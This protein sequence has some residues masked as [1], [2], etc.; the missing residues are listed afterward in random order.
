MLKRNGIAFVADEVVTGFGRTGAMF[1]SDTFG[2][3][4]DH[5]VIAKGITSGYFPL[6]AVAIGSELYADLETGSDRVGTFAHAATYAA[7]PVG[8]AAALKVMEIIERDDLVA[9]AA[10][11]GQRLAA[12]LEKLG[13][14]PLIG[15]VR[16]VGLAG[17]LD[18]LRR[19]GDDRPVNDDA[20]A[21]SISVYERALDAGVVTRPA[22]RSLVIAPPLIVQE[23][24]IDEICDRI[25]RALDAV[26]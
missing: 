10:R 8:A 9:H 5:A 17:A 11:M 18:F 3:K 2:L 14:H 12:R 15:D 23:A 26:D 4:P 19:D 25:E 1:G 16:H 22:G 24:E 7:H 13:E 6:S 21:L 20:D